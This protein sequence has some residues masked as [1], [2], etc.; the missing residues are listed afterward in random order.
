MVSPAPGTTFNGSTITFQWTAGSATAYALTLGSSA[1]TVDIYNSGTLH[2][3]S[4]TVNN[5]PADGRT[6]YATLYSQVNNNW[7][8]TVYTY[9]AFH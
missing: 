1:R 6:V 8:S 5:I 2:T 7:V 9:T 3:L 4:V